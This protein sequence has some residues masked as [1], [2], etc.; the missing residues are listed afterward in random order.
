MPTL[1]V[2]LKSGSQCISFDIGQSLRQILDTADVRVRSG[3]GGNGACG[4]C[5]VRIESGKVS[6]PTKNERIHLDNVKLSE[7]I[8]LACQVIPEQDL[9]I[10]ILAPGRKSIWRRLDR[11]RDCRR[12]E[13]ALAYPSGSLIQEVKRPYG[14]AVDLG[15]THIR[16]SLYDLNSGKL[17][18]GRYGVNPQTYLGSDVM[19][20]LV[21]ASESPKHAQAMSQ[22]VIGAISGALWDI[23]T[24]EG[25]D[26]GKVVRLVL[27]GNTAMLALLSKRNSDMLLQPCHW[28]TEIDC[29]PKETKTW[30]VEWGIHPKA[31][32]EIIPPLA[33]FVGSDLLAGV[34]MTNLTENAAGSLFIDFGTNSEIALWDGKKL[35]VTSA[36][37]GPAFEGSGIGCGFPA[38]PGAI[39]RFRLKDGDPDFDVIAGREPC[40]ICGSG[41]VDLIAALIHSGMLTSKGRFTPAVND[42]RFTLIQGEGSIVL[43]QKDV[44]V[45]Q[46]AKAAIGAGIQILLTKAS[47]SLKALRRVCIGGAFGHYLNVTNAQQIGLLP[48]TQ[49]ALV[50][51]CGG[52]ALAGCEE[53]ILSPVSIERLMCIREK[54]TM[55]NLS[56]YSDFDDFFLNNL[57][58]HPLKE[59]E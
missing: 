7:N 26:L 24:R 55:I 45:F 30:A 53:M 28:T 14:V 49:T 37:G 17:M 5:L 25:I 20:R 59:V 39:Y 43:T 48:H 16:L 31:E 46:R 9:E 56:Q 35:W 36:A 33:G 3:C 19:T 13:R 40:G 58:L 34:L 1:I 54:A 42:N 38:E 32:I 22:E 6:E 41:L 12:S 15:T 8:R 10:I 47:M 27:V 2:R 29:T 50:E 57:Y 4:L 21:N 44:D 11:S 23:A 18:A 51:L 52:T